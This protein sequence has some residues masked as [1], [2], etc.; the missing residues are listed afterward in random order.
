MK[1][2]YI[3]LD[4]REDRKTLMEQNWNNLVEL[5]RFN[6]VKH[7]VGLHGVY[8]SHYRVLKMLYDRCEPLSIIME[9]DVIPCK[10]FNERLN[11]FMSELPTDWDIFMLGFFSTERSSF[12]KVSE[13]IYKAKDRICGGQCYIVNPKSYDKILSKFDNKHYAMNLD[14]LLLDVQKTDNVYLSIPTFTYQ[15]DSYSDNSKS[16]SS[17]V[18]Q[19]TKIYFKDEL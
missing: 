15:Y 3:N 8:E 7:D 10:D 18:S 6:A 13:N 9:D 14:V 2:Y 1:G 4:H 5:N 19:A 11:L 16:D 12:E 17:I